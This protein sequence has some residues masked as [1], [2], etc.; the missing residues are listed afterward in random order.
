MPAAYLVCERQPGQ[1]LQGARDGLPSG[2]ADDNGDIDEVNS[3]VKVMYNNTCKKMKQKMAP[4]A[5]KQ[6]S[7]VPV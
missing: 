7:L 2:S 6:V 3:D 1:P 5:N 4:V